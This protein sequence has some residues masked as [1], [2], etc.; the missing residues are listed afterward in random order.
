MEPGMLFIDDGAPIA[1]WGDT[2]T[3]HSIREII[4]TVSGVPAALNQVQCGVFV[5]GPVHMKRDT[6]TLVK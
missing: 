2:S 6:S 4:A 5:L 1:K 3:A